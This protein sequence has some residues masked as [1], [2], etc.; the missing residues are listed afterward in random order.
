MIRLGE[1]RRD[2]WPKS[3]QGNTRRS[4]QTGRS[5]RFARNNWH[6]LSVK[7]NLLTREPEAIQLSRYVFADLN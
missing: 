2:A 4:A 5:R 1:L 7:T 3:P 6:C